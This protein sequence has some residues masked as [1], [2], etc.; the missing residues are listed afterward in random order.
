MNTEKNE[1]TTGFCAGCGKHCPLNAL[2]CGLGYRLLE[3]QSSDSAAAPLENGAG[4]RGSKGQRAHRD[5]GEGHRRHEQ[6]REHGHGGPVERE[7]RRGAGDRHGHDRHRAH[8]HRGHGGRHHGDA[9]PF[10]R[11]PHGPRLASA[12]DERLSRVF[13]HC[14]RTLVHRERSQG[15][16]ASAL[17]VLASHGAMSQ[18][19]LAD[20]LDI[21]AASTSELLAKME[22]D[23]LVVR[24]PDADDGRAYRVELTDAGSLEAQRVRQE[25]SERDAQLF[26]ALDADEKTELAALLDKLASSWR[27]CHH[28]R[29][30]KQD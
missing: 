30:P 7:G 25:R 16:R 8:D 18:A 11:G 5:H 19:A 4:N 15:G 29:A 21:R 17:A 24:T 2:E 27:Q 3:E 20:K 28:G 14:A 26:D 10:D 23:G 9:S 1:T 22:A 13:H 6:E 12:E